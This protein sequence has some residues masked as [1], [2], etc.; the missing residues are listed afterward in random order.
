VRG[1]R[2]AKGEDKKNL[3]DVARRGRRWQ[4]R[5]GGDW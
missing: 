1:A 5:D 3:R 4:R 2:R